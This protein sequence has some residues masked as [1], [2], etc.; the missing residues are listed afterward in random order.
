MCDVLLTC[1]QENNDKHLTLAINKNDI[2]VIFFPLILISYSCFRNVFKLYKVCFEVVLK[3]F[4]KLNV[5]VNK[6]K[7]NKVLINK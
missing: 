2:H 6:V 4:K 5:N 7:K 3:L 1:L